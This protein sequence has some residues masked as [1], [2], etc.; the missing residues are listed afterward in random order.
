MWRYSD[1]VYRIHLQL[2][3]NIDFAAE[4][5]AFAANPQGEVQLADGSWLAQA[6]A[7]ADGFDALTVRLEDSKGHVWTVFA[8]DLA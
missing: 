4:A 6:D 5:D 7:Q 8:A 3:Y 2:G 1:D